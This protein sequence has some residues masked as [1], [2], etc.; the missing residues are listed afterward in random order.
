MKEKKKPFEGSPTKKKKTMTNWEYTIF[1]I[2]TNVEVWS[3]SVEWIKKL[4]DLGKDGWE[5]VTVIPLTSAGSITGKQF[6]LKRKMMEN[7]T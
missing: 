1:S 3:V 6:I 2:K 7:S 5:L 4:N